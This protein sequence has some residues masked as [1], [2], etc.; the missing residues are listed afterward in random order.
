[1]QL[2]IINSHDPVTADAISSFERRIGVALPEQYTT[3]LRT[4]NGGKFRGRPV[5][6]TI[7]KIPGGVGGIDFFLGLTKD[8]RTFDDLWQQLGQGE[9]ETVDRVPNLLG[10]AVDGC[11]MIFLCCEGKYRGKVY[12]RVSD[13]WHL[14][15]VANSFNA[16]LDSVS[17][18]ESFESTIPVFRAVEAGDTD[19]LQ[20]QIT[21]GVDIEARN[22]EQETLLMFACKVESPRCVTWLLDAG[23]KVDAV[24][25]QGEQPIHLATR[26]R[27]LDCVRILVARGAN[28]N[29]TT[30]SRKSPL[31]I[32][33]D[34]YSGSERMAELIVE[35]GGTEIAADTSGRNTL[36]MACLNENLGVCTKL[37]ER[38]ANVEKAT[39]WVVKQIVTDSD[40]Q[41]W[42]FVGLRH[43]GA[44][45]ELIDLSA[46]GYTLAMDQVL[47]IA[48]DRA[49]FHQALRTAM[50]NA[51]DDI[52]DYAKFILEEA[53]ENQSA[54]DPTL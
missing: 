16:F 37:I 4:H 46:K 9:L 2:E 22:A 51:D 3:F 24:T 45:D 44:V 5:Y 39:A 14:Y 25:D 18:P 53:Q 38:G 50:H 52:A 36:G 49:D 54:E 10:V 11:G 23:A 33:L 15:L 7:D 13:G 6:P 30:S 12:I 1:M 41:T 40:L 27:V 8:R 21:T 29:A 31:Y 48:P 35:L 28:I 20:E 42:G 47:A 17:A 43:L 32:S 26:A 34:R 19:A